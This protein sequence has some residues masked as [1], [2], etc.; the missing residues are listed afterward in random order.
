MER[1]HCAAAVGILTAWNCPSYALWE[2]PMQTLLYM[3]QK[4][5]CNSQSTKKG[6][7][8]FLTMGIK[9]HYL[10]KTQ[11]FSIKLRKLCVRE[12][13]SVESV[14]ELQE[15]NSKFKSLIRKTNN[16]KKTISGSKFGIPT[17]FFFFFFYIISSTLNCS[18]N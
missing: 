18:S 15:K 6:E 13:K 1:E 12:L 3:R 11:C 14:E 8:Y 7:K 10:K 5:N 2:H 16:N 4:C 17:L 9:F